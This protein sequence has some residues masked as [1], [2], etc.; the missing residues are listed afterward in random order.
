MCGGIQ[1][2]LGLDA[3]GHLQGIESRSC[4]LG[5]RLANCERVKAIF[6]QGGCRIAG[7]SREDEPFP[8]RGGRG[9]ALQGWRA[10]YGLWTDGVRGNARQRRER[11]FFG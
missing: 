3:G 4:L 6:R 5:R 8:G 2:H 10:F 11:R 1:E 9:K 7:S